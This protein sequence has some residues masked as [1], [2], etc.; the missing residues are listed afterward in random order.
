MTRLRLFMRDS[1]GVAA[2]EFAL[3]LPVLLLMTAGIIEYGRVLFVEQAVRNIIDAAVRR[4]VVSAMTS[5]A[6]ETQVLDELEGVHG[7]ED[8]EVEV[9]DGAELSVAVSGTFA[10]AFGT[11]L[12]DGMIDFEVTTQF[13]R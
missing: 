12:P 10:L 3:I 4:G 1:D 2:V 11:L 8:F 9:G 7:I 13:P 5:E 6:V